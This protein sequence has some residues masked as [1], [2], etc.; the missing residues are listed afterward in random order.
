MKTNVIF[1]TR[2]F[3]AMTE[4]RKVPEYIRVSGHNPCPCCGES[5]R[6]V[7]STEGIYHVEC[8][9]CGH[10]S[11]KSF[12]FCNQEPYIAIDKVKYDWNRE[13]ILSSFTSEALDAMGVEEGDYLAV[14]N[15]EDIV[16]LVASTKEEILDYFAY[17]SEDVY[18][19]L[20]VVNNG[21]LVSVTK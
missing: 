12:P 13:F 1:T 21:S 7:V 4:K 15:V 6:G 19:K 3:E 11:E 14:D 17:S 18:Y 10:R 20:Y 16:L 5:V 8:Q 9:T 2:D